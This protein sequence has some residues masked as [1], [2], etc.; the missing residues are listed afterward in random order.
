MLNMIKRVFRYLTSVQY[1]C[2]NEW[3]FHRNNMNDLTKDLKVLKDSNNFITHT[4]DLKWDVYMRDY[5][6][7]IKKCILKEDVT[8]NKAQR[9]LFM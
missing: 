5:V 3:K 2:L 9:R 8:E 4:N 7:G 1:F 6:I